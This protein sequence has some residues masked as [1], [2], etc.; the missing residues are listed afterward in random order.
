MGE[1]DKTTKEEELES[2]RCPSCGMR[3]EKVHHLNRCK[4]SSRRAVFERQIQVLEEWMSST[5]THPLLEKWLSTYLRGHGKSFQLIPNLP[6]AM[7]RIAEEQDAIGW[8]SF[9]EG[10]VTRR[11]PM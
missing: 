6:K 9:A 1:T 8:T 5:Y 11:I 2:S 7:R 10:R 4:N 3:Q